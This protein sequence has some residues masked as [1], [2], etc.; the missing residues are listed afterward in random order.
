MEICFDEKW[1]KLKK[2]VTFYLTEDDSVTVTVPYKGNP[3][4]IPDSVTANGG[5]RRYVV[6]G[7]GRRKK[8]VS[9]T[10]FL[11]VIAVPESYLAESNKKGKVGVAK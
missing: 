10:G 8:L 5:I 9:R 1:D 3:I 11:S 2:E 4:M 7:T 6:K